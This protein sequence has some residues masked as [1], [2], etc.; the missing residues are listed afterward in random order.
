[1]LDAA[2]FSPLGIFFPAFQTLCP[3]ATCPSHS[4]GPQLPSSCH[5]W[6][7]E[8]GR[9]IFQASLDILQRKL[10]QQCHAMAV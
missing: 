10:T 3:G 1:M 6:A 8:C 7:K 9:D 5:P 4:L 2:V